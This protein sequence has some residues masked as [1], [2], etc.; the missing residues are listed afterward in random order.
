[1]LHPT[2]S[3]G[4]AR[5]CTNDAGAIDAFGPHIGQSNDVNADTIYLCLGDSIFIDHNN[6][7]DLSGDPNPATPAGVGYTFFDCP[8]TVSGTTTADIAADPCVTNTGGPQYGYYIYTGGVLTGDVYFFNNGQLQTTLNG[9]DPTI[10]HF[11]PITFDELSA[12]TGL[13]SYEGTPV[14]DCVNLNPNASF[15]VAYLNALEISELSV[16]GCTGSFRVNGGLSELDN[17][18]YTINIYDQADNSIVA[19]VTGGPFNNNDLVNF[20]A[21]SPG[22]YIIEVEDGK[23]CGA[24]AMVTV[25]NCDA[26]VLNFPFENVLPGTNECVPVTVDNFN[27]LIAAQMTIIWDPAVLQ[28][29]GVQGFHPLVP[30]LNVGTF[31]YAPLAAG[32]DPGELT[33]AWTDPTLSGITIN[34]GETLFEICFDVLGDIGTSTPINVQANNAPTP[35]EITRSNSE[36]IGLIS[37]SG[38]IVV[39]DDPFFVY[40]TQDSLTC[41]SF[42]DG[43]FTVLVD[44]G[45]APYRFFWNTIPLSGANNGPFVIGASGSSETISNLPSGT[46]AITITDSSIPSLEVID[47]IDV[48][49]GAVLGIT[50]R[51]TIPTCFGASDGA[52]EFVPTSN[53]APV[54][55]PGPEYSFTWSVPTGVN[56]PGNVNHATG[57]PSGSYG[58]TISDGAGCEESALIPLGQP[59]ILRVLDNSTFIANASCTGGEDGSISITATGGTTADGNYNYNWDT[60]LNINANTSTIAN[61]NPGEYCVTI[62]DDN[63]CTEERCF[64]VGAVKTLSINDVITDADCFGEDSGSILITGSTTGAPADEPYNFTWSTNA[65]APTNT[66][67]TSMV[68]DLVAATYYVTM[69]DSG[70]ATCSVVDSFTVNEPTEL[71]ASILSFSNETCTVGNDGSITIAANGGVYP[72]SY[73]WSHDAMLTDSVANNLSQATYTIEVT[74]ANGCSQQLMQDVSAPTPPLVTSFNDDSVTC[75]DDTDGILLVNVTPA[76]GTNIINYEW[77]NGEMGA[78]ANAITALS[79]GQYVV[80]ITADNA[81]VTIDT[82]L[83]TAPDPILLDSFNITEPTCPGEQS[84]QIAVFISGGTPTYTYQW[85]TGNFPTSQVHPGLVAG[86][87]T[88]VVEDDN[89][90]SSQQFN[91]AVSDPP[92][93]VGVLSNAMDTSC[94][95]DM[96]CDGQ[97]TASASYADGSTGSFSFEWTSG[98]IDFMTTTSTATQLCEGMNN[99]IIRDDNNCSTQVDFETGA[100]DDIN[101]ASSIVPV[102]CNGGMDGSISIMPTGGTAPYTYLWPATG[103]AADNI[104]NLA[105]G[106]YTVII[107][108]ANNC[109]FT[110]NIEVSEPAPLVAS[111]DASQTTSHVSC[112]GDEDG[113]IAV[114]ATG[115][116]GSVDNPYTY[117]WSDNSTTSIN[118]NLAA[119]TYMVTVSDF[120]NCT[121]ELTYTIQAPPIIEFR[122]DTIQPPLCFGDATE[123]SIDTVFGGAG[124]PF[125]EY[126]FMIDNNGLNFPVQSTATVFAGDHLVTVTDI[127]GCTAEQSVNIISP[128]QIMIELADIIE[129]E[130]GDSTMQMGTR[131]EPSD[132]YMIQWTPAE[133]LSAD[134]IENPFVYPPISTDYSITVVNE[135]GCTATAS[136]FVEVDANRNVY[137]PNVFNPDGPNETFKIYTC[138]GVREITSARLFDRWGGLL[139]EE[140]NL[141]PACTNGVEIWDG[142]RAGEKLNPGVYVYI[143]EIEFLDGVTL[144][145]RGDVTLLRS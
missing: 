43:S 52:I 51:D 74:D 62:T 27:D 123:I 23:S 7:V 25:D 108:D 119:G 50:I 56:N 36:E 141:A 86:D 115:G 109:T 129:V 116:N 128:Q 19:S 88:L 44:Q 38:A 75:A 31:G 67:T 77:S 140:T 101:S 49:A 125:E 10:Y 122:L 71:Q 14:G 138:L 69:T 33:I 28:I 79:P 133:H 12:V 135:N 65:P 22:T 42:D 64:T 5:M 110:Q 15:A 73:S 93:I 54:D 142:I 34:N 107:T 100:P 130:L 20:T 105:Q 58:I 53:G 113:I 46:Y 118:T 35:I 144:T 82:A 137:I 55:N 29:S 96:T 102:S 72:Y 2:E 114:S 84:G 39:S 1:M 106:Q 91:F 92:A 41:P 97:M 90:C 112:A 83:V 126:T 103:S 32:L 87:Y 63:N 89:G 3:V 124:N 121:D 145:Y 117:V 45:T 60:G 17:S 11:A 120:K 78:T 134:T 131:I 30:G 48:L 66:T 111:I 139:V 70:S 40:T 136:T 4:G 98:Q 95:D 8:P 47:T 13:A 37:N 18:N 104:N 85:S 57:V 59:P 132:N 143:I 80:T 61:L 21:P 99:V 94:P 9:G 26:L 24:T 68:E 127:N 6:I 16:S 81:C 76:P